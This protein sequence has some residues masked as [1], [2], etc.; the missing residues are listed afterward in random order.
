MLLR[1]HL[2]VACDHVSLSEH[3]KLMLNVAELCPNSIVPLESPH[4]IGRY[5]C[6]VHALGFT[7]KPEYISIAS[8]PGTNVFA[9]KNFAEW[10]L[11]TK[12]LT[13]VSPH[14]AYA[15]SMVMYFDDTHD[16]THVGLLV[17]NNRVQSKWGTLGL[18]E[19]G[20]FEVPSNYGEVARY[21]MPL[22]YDEAIEL[23]YE[24]AKIEGIE[25]Q[26]K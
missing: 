20:L 25:F 3:T 6:L 13:E 22:P 2:T 8:M 18:Y 19:H 17:T 5:T 12:S 9:G 4:D 23:F 26:D 21:F 16:F 11:T 24:F 1:E 10:L 7:E 14:E 15:G